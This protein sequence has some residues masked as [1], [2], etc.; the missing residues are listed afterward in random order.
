MPEDYRWNQSQAAADYD[1]AA[2]VIHPRYVEVQDAVL[3]ALPFDVRAEFRV[4]DLGGG[5]GRL[6]ERVLDAYPLATVVVLDQSAPFVTLAHERLR[7]FGARARTQRRAMQEDW[8]SGLAP[9]DAIVSTSAIHHLDSAEKLALFRK[10]R[11]ALAHGG[12][13]INGDEHRPEDDTAYRELLERW[14]QHME[15][16]HAR[17][18]IPAS[19]GEV[20]AKWRERNLDEFGAP[21][22]SGDDCHETVERQAELLREAGFTRVS[23]PWRAE[24]WAVS[25]AE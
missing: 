21:R 12:V 11:G 24:L 9:V 25:V 18:E 1:A 7:R 15:W 19:F 8:Q 17:G 16:A 23:V 2:P 22:K 6:A 5:S 4:L 10:C 20:I 14:G 3:A 13:L